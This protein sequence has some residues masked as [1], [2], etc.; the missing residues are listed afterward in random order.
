VYIFF[1]TDRSVNVSATV[2]SDSSL[3]FTVPSSFASTEI[4]Y[5]FVYVDNIG[6]AGAFTAQ[7][8]A[9]LTTFTPSS[10]SIYGEILT[11]TGA[12]FQSSN[13]VQLGGNTCLS[14]W[15]SSTIIVAHCFTPPNA[16]LQNGKVY[17]VVV[18]ADATLN[19]NYSVTVT[20]Q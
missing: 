13:V 11:L 17:S 12:G 19:A 5:V 4:V 1:G 14:E 16:P 20:A 2:T 6:Y 7:I 18:Y 8:L 9:K 10:G 3:Q 15:Q